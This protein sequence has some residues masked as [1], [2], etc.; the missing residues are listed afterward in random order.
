MFYAIRRRA[1]SDRQTLVEFAKKADMDATS[2]S[3]GN[4]YSIVPAKIAREWVRRG[5]EHETGLYLDGGSIRYA[6]PSN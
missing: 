6:N 3:K 2:V 1:G 5:R 4:V